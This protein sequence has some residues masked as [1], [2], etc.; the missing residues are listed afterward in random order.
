[1]LLPLLDCTAPPYPAAVFR[2]EVVWFIWQMFWISKCRA[3]PVLLAK[4]PVISVLLNVRAFTLET[5]TP[6]PLSTAVFPLNE[7]SMNLMALEVKSSTTPNPF[8]TPEYMA[9]P[10]PV[11]LLL[12]KLQLYIH[13][14]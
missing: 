11:A 6:P 4:L 1:M 12:V 13:K 14:G 2:E 9:P 8:P 7:V 5:Y 3:P 10:C